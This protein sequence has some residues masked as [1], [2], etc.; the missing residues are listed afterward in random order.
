MTTGVTSVIMGTINA[1]HLRANVAV[2]NQFI[3]NLS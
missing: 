1:A 3:M 2:Y